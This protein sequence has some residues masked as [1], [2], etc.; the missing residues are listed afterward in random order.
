MTKQEEFELLVKPLIEWLN[1]N[2]HPH[3]KILVEQTRAEIL[4][5]LASVVTEEFLV[6]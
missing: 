3:T 6:D 5:G 2:Y 1:K 4:E